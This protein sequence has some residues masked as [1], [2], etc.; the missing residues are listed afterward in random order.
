MLEYGGCREWY[1]CPCIE[2]KVRKD[3]RC[4]RRSAPPRD[5]AL[6]LRARLQN[7]YIGDGSAFALK[8]IEQKTRK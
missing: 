6:V 8:N 4:P 7:T 2:E 1:Y 3:A 5:F